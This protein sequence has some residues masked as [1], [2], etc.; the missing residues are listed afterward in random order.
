ML[1]TLDITN[2]HA[3]AGLRLIAARHATRL[4]AAVSLSTMIWKELKIE[5]MVTCKFQVNDTD[6]GGPVGLMFGWPTQY[7]LKFADGTSPPNLRRGT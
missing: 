1:D 3:W 4:L 6:V 7:H 5:P 2:A